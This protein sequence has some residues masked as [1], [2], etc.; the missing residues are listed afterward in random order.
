MERGGGEEGRRGEESRA[1]ERNRSP[2]VTHC[3]ESRDRVNTYPAGDYVCAQMCM[4]DRKMGDFRADSH[5]VL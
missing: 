1:Q 4:L 3:E 2:T 5:W